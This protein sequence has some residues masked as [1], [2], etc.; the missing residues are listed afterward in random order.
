MAIKV[1]GTTVINDSRALSNIAS[2][3]ATT[4]A[5]MGA[6]GVGGLHTQ[7]VAENTST[8]ANG[9]S[10]TLG[11]FTLGNYRQQTFRFEG[12]QRTGGGGG[13]LCCRLTNG[14]GTTLTSGYIEAGQTQVYMHY[15][16]QAGHSVWY[17]YRME[18]MPNSS[19]GDM[20]LEVT[21]SDAYS[22]TKRTTAIFN[23]WGYSNYDSDIS[24]SR[25]NATRNT[26]E[27]N[28]SFFLYFENGGTYWESGSTYSSWGIA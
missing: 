28:N 2:V 10:A 21:F 19:Q 20:S 17:W 16:S 4:A 22:S 1:S 9:T 15:E 18:S 27:K 13:R 5:A 7:I 6:A 12:L 14:S 24:G 23:S 11:P 3:D 26:V 25:V 8:G